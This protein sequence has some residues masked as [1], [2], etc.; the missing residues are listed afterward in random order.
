MTMDEKDVAEIM[1]LL[2]PAIRMILRKEAFRF[3]LEELYR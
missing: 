1:H 2:L 3:S